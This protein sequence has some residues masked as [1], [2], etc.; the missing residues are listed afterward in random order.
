MLPT[1]A[2][3]GAPDGSK[4]AGAAVP[5]PWWFHGHAPRPSWRPFSNGPGG[6]RFGSGTRCG[7]SFPTERR[8]KRDRLRASVRSP[9]RRLLPPP[10]WQDRDLRGLQKFG[11][12]QAPQASEPA[13]VGFP[14]T[15]RRPLPPAPHDPWDP[16][17]FPMKTIR[18]NAATKSS[19]W[20]AVCSV[21]GPARKLRR[22]CTVCTIVLPPSPQ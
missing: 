18:V 6:V 21:V 14:Q 19:S 17:V 1:L 8:T 7:G 10:C 12:R 9:W 3:K 15:T 2:R 5:N 22:I 16:Q 20:I 4:N 13:A 11:D